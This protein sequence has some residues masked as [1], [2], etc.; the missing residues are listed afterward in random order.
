MKKPKLIAEIGGN[1]QGSFE[2]AIELVD[3]AIKS[4]ADI[5]KMQ[6]YSGEGLVNPIIDSE[7]F[8]H[9]KKFQLSIDQHLLIAQRIKSSGKSY[10]AS[11][12]DIQSLKILGDYMDLYKIGSGDMT[13]YQIISYMCENPKPLIISTGLSELRE[14]DDV[15]NFVR[16]AND[17]FNESENLILLQCTSMYP[18]ENSDANLHVMETYK[19]RYKCHVG[20]SDHTIG[21]E[22]LFIAGLAGA[23]FLE[24]HFTD[25]KTNLTFRDHC[26]SLEKTDVN[27]LCMRFNEAGILLGSFEKNILNIEVANGHVQGFRR[28]VY[29]KHDVDVNTIIKESDIVCLRPN[30]GIDAR[31]Y[32]DFIGAKTKRAI[33]A[34]EILSLDDFEF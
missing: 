7:R 20:Y 14:V 16:N 9:F 15:V 28:A 17:F 3:L 33:R 34:F 18:I 26:V 19:N 12:W 6:V 32:K 31:R 4:E 23:D 11:V 30:K 5:I 29:L 1:H 10:L 13:N 25:D 22:A 24:F 21:N 8:E 2:R 27:N